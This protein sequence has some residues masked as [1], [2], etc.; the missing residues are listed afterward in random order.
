MFLSVRESDISKKMDCVL[1]AAKSISDKVII[2]SVPPRRNSINIKTLNRMWNEAAY[3]CDN[4][5]FINCTDSCYVKNGD[6]FDFN[7][8][9]FDDAVH[10]SMQTTNTICR[11]AGVLIRV[12][13]R[14]LTSSNP[15]QSTPITWKNRSNHF[16][17]RLRFA[18][19]MKKAEHQTRNSSR[20]HASRSAKPTR[21]LRDFH[22]SRR[23]TGL[24]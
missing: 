19:S 24:Q 21:H 7:R 11:A 8:P 9:A 14:F 6:S 22:N 3:D 17:N 1:N 2:M 20:V 12:G 16:S 5:E 10:P 13:S 15:H 23:E 18:D 4:V